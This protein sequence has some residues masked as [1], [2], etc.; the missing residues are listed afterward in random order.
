MP[1][2][3]RAHKMQRLHVMVPVDMVDTINEFQSQTLSD[4]KQEVVRRALQLYFAIGNHVLDGAEVVAHYPEGDSVSLSL[5][6]P[7]FET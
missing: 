7:E 2:N 6:V 5:L 3:S 1:R 4:S